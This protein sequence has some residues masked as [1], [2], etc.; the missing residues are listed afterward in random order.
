MEGRTPV[1]DVDAHFEP[2]LDWLDEFPSLKAELPE[3]LPQDDPRFRLGSPEMFAF[4][5]SDD[6]LRQVPVDERPP[7]DE[8]V[9]PAMHLMLGEER[10]HDLVYQGSDQYPPL[11]PTDV[12]DRLTWMDAAGI[13]KQNAISGGGYTLARVIG[14]PGLGQRAL[15]AVNT[16]LADRLADSAGRVLPVTC[17]R[18][19]DLDWA[20]REMTRM[21]GLGSRTFLVSAEPAGGIAPSTTAFDP[22]WSAATDLGMVP[23]LHVGMAPAL[24]HPGW[25]RGADPGLVRL[26]S[27]L[28]PDQAAQVY[29]TAL[30]FGGVFERH[31]TLSLMVSELGIEWVPRLVTRLDVM[32]QPGVSPVVLGEYRLPRTPGEYFREHIRVSPVP[33]LREAPLDLLAELPE[34]GVFSSDFPHHEGNGD[35]VA[36]Y[37][38]VLVDVDPAVSAGFLGGNIA[39]SYERMGDPL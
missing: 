14:D 15:E 27:V 9:T 16:Y 36:Y 11:T 33:A 25:A 18:F 7:I 3:L 21:R 13:D 22:V 37:R 4:F 31:P 35:P 29:L 38:E 5:L 30:V 12:G 24:I 10:L 20:V 8:L 34:V 1:I 28:Q 26:L 39:A 19:D 23:L 6:L 17:L 32:A 2:P